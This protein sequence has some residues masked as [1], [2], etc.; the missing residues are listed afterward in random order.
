M[1][2]KIRYTI[3]LTE[4]LNQ[5]V[6]DIADEAGIPKSEVFRRALALLKVAQKA[7]KRGEHVGI[8]K[9]GQESLKTEFVFR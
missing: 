7:A 5:E 6:E 3:D 1:A 8:G 9:D 2:K 4:E